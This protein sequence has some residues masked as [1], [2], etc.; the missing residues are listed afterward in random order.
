[1]IGGARVRQQQLHRGGDQKKRNRGK[2]HSF[3][4]DA[5]AAMNAPRQPSTSP[6]VLDD[7][8]GG[9]RDGAGGH[10]DIFSELQPIS[11]DPLGENRVAA[12]SDDHYT[13]LHSTHFTKS[14]RIKHGT[15]QSVGNI[16]DDVVAGKRIEVAER[17]KATSLD[18]IRHQAEAAGAARNFA[19][20][21]VRPAPHGIHLIAEIKQRS[22]SA[23]LIR[24]DFDPVQIARVYESSGASAISVLTDRKYFGG[25]LAHIQ[26][27]RDAVALPV[28][29]KDFILDEYQIYEARAAGADAVLLIAEV[30]GVDVI[31]QFV[32]VIGE[33][34]MTALVE[35]Y[36]PTLMRQVLA[37]LGDPPPSHVLIGINN[38]DLTRQVT[39]LATT[40]RLADL[41]QDRS[42]LVSESGIASRENVLAVQSAGA[43]AMLVGESILSAADIAK[44]IKS[45]LG[46]Q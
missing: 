46:F 27:V 34:G 39:D 10:Q 9:Q 24:A 18:E 40:R 12:R 1:M 20:A 7:Q 14:K 45:L 37:A 21:I 2:Q 29:R 35:S 33:L 16:L 4:R 38:R 22:P 13:R 17:K 5:G 19:A 15:N 44:R 26:Q 32:G 23:G 6:N 42:R 11:A 41:M 36:Q 25:D 3:E 43:A 8:V 31:Q 28:L 30:L